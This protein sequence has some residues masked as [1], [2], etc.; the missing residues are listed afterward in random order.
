MCEMGE[1]AE[2]GCKVNRWDCLTSTLF[3]SRDFISI[4]YHVTSLILL[5]CKVFT[6][7]E[8]RDSSYVRGVSW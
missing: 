1:C 2:E 7:K 6:R 5:M 3:R 8:K 4:N